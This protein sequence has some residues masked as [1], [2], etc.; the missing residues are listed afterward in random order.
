MLRIIPGLGER[1]L[2]KVLHGDVSPEVQPITF[3]YTIFD[4]KGTP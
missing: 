3:L 2:N 1:E 4:R